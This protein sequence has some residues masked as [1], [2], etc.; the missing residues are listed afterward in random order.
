MLLSGVLPLLV[1][2]DEIFEDDESEGG[3]NACRSTTKIEEETNV[4]SGVKEP[5]PVE[6]T[7]PVCKLTLVS[8]L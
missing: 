6:L 8:L 1:L 5:I 7:N 3:K 2:L 4:T